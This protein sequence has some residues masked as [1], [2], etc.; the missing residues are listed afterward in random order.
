MAFDI[1]NLNANITSFSIFDYDGG[2]QIAEVLFDHKNG[3]VKLLNSFSDTKIEFGSIKLSNRG[4]NGGVLNRIWLNASPNA[5]T[6]RIAIYLMP[7]GTNGS[8]KSIFLHG[9]FLIKGK[10]FVN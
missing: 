10:V 4:P 3:K 6:K 9:S 1:E 2:K 7:V 5:Q 8:G